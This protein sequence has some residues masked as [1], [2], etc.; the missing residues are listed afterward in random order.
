MNGSTLSRLG[1]SRP[2]GTARHT[3]KVLLLLLLV[4][5]LL[6]SVA[7][8]LLRWS[9]RRSTVSQLMS[10]D[11]GKRAEVIE[12]IYQRHEEGLYIQALIDRL[13]RN[14]RV[15]AIQPLRELGDPARER[16]LALLETPARRGLDPRIRQDALR[17]KA[18]ALTCLGVV[19]D[20]RLV[21]AI[22]RA[23]SVDMITGQHIGDAD[24]EEEFLAS[25]GSVL[26]RLDAEGARTVLS[27][28]A[29]NGMPPIFERALGMYA[30]RADL[31][32]FESYIDHPMLGSTMATILAEN[33]GERGR[34]ILE[35]RLLEHDT[36]TVR[37]DIALALARAQGGTASHALQEY[38]LRHSRALEEVYSQYR[39]LLMSDVRIDG[40]T[41][42]CLLFALWYYGPSDPDMMA[43]YKNSRFYGAKREAELLER[44]L[45]TRGVADVDL[46]R[47][48]ERLP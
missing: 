10:A 44:T 11:A 4:V 14:E 34:S 3:A 2:H 41:Y 32:I 33:A 9:T 13:G 22:E 29:Q 23:L 47:P 26:S 25:A 27:V 6:L 40:S 38:A 20:S 31:S 16:L 24:A 43:S 48:V 15:M 19:V 28:C 39:A 21:M 8:V 36:D 35:T 42:K 7:G 37:W 18:C 30:G 1:A 45:V 5:C 46:E 17:A 12:A